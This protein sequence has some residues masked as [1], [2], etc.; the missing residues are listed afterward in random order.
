MGLLE[1]IV[2]VLVVTAGSLIVGVLLF[3]RTWRKR[4]RERDPVR[5]AAEEAARKGRPTDAADELVRAA[6]DK[7]DAGFYLKALRLFKE[8]L[9]HD[10]QHAEALAGKRKCEDELGLS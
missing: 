6:R 1:T 2:A 4:K 7:L 9:E 5:F 8:A 10:P 3:R